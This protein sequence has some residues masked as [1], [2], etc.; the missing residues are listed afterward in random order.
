MPPSRRVLVKNV[1][2]FG[3]AVVSALAGGYLVHRHDG[4]F[5]DVGGL[6]LLLFSLICMAPTQIHEM[7]DE[8]R[9]AWKTF[10]NPG[11]AS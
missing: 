10:K 9:S 2:L 8:L 6:L 7:G 11:G 3:A 5:D 4:R 1:Q